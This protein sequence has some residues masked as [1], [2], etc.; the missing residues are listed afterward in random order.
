LF[1]GFD[2]AHM[3]HRFALETCVPHVHVRLTKREKTMNSRYL[4][5]IAATAMLPLAVTAQ[6]THSD[7]AD[8]AAATQ[9]LQHESAFRNYQRWREAEESPAKAWRAMN[10]ELAAP[11][12][13]EGMDKRMPAMDAAMH[14]SD[15]HTMPHRHERK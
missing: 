14:S 9:G 2:A 12:G 8:P 5:T 13:M 3:P 11:S 1:C 7:P 4:L 15:T 10:D 6:S